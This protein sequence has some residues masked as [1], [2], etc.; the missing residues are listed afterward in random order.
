VLLAHH[1][2]SEL[3]DVYDVWYA[4]LAY[5]PKGSEA[6]AQAKPMGEPPRTKSLPA[7]TSALK[8]DLGQRLVRIARAAVN[9]ELAGSN[10]LQYELSSLPASSPLDRQQAVYVRLFVGGQPRGCMGQTESQFWLP[11]AVVRAALDAALHDPKSKPIKPE[12]L[13]KLSVEV[14]LLTPPQTIDSRDDIQLGMHGIVLEK[15]QQRAVLLPQVPKEGGWSLIKTLNTLARDAGLA[16]RAWRDPDVK[17]SI[18]TGQVFREEGGSAPAS[19]A[20]KKR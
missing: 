3:P 15:E 20:Q 1:S 2:S 17:L 12:E 10:N 9:T 7:D 11:E 18:F 6:P 16:G 14:T 19:P 13:E 4:S 5:L 8:P